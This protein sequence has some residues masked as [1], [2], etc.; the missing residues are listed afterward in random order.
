MAREL[1]IEKVERKPEARRKP[2]VPEPNKL[3]EWVDSLGDTGSGI[4]TSVAMG[5]I[6]IAVALLLNAIFW[7]LPLARN[8]HP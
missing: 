2:D 7:H 3:Q 6:I 5:V 8:Y 4:F 1:T